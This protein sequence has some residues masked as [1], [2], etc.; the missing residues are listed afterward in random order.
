MVQKRTYGD[1]DTFLNNDDAQMTN[2]CHKCI[3]LG[4]IH[5]LVCSLLKMGVH[6]TKDAYTYDRG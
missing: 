3:I 5:W 1:R 6:F 2:G 4:D